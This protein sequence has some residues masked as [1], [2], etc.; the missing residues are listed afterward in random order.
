MWAALRPDRRSRAFKCPP[1]IQGRVQG[2]SEPPGVRCSEA[3][4]FAFAPSGAE[5]GRMGL[6]LP[7]LSPQPASRETRDL[8]QVDSW[9]P[10]LAT[11]A[12]AAFLLSRDGA[13]KGPS[14][15]PQKAQENYTGFLNVSKSV[16]KARS[17]FC[18]ELPAKTSWVSR[19][20]CQLSHPRASGH[21]S[22]PGAEMKPRESSR[23]ELRPGQVTS[24]PVARGLLHTK[25]WPEPEAQ[26]EFE[27]QGET[28]P[29]QGLGDVAQGRWS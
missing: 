27:P 24:L 20:K 16:W 6:L 19:N 25:L 5:G 10:E 3:P 11:S 7:P 15:N 17:C 22:A 23:T 13:S 4:G 18:A 9:Q 28:K 8:Q 1:G 12:Q 26:A 14:S 29:V 21:R 2:S